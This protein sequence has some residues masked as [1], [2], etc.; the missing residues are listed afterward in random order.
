MVLGMPHRFKNVERATPML[1]PP[2]LRDWVAED[3]LV[4]FVIQ[5]VERLPLSSFAVNAKGCGDEPDLDAQ[6]S[7]NHALRLNG[8]TRSIARSRHLIATFVEA[9]GGTNT[10]TV[11]FG[12]GPTTPTRTTIERIIVGTVDWETPKATNV[13]DLHWHKPRAEVV[14]S[15]PTNLVEGDFSGWYLLSLDLNK[16]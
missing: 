13:L 1:L 11:S 12:K 4:H 7:K 3:D 5:A 16:K 14:F 9:R 15:A 2:D 6:M 8:A 10:I